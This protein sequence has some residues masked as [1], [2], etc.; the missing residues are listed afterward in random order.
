MAD[1]IGT[2]D[3]IES[4]DFVLFNPRVLVI[5]AAT[6]APDEAEFG[7]KISSQDFGVLE[8]RSEPDT[9]AFIGEAQYLYDADLV[10]RYT[11]DPKPGSLVLYPAATGLEKAMADTDAERLIRIPDWV[12]IDQWDPWLISFNNL[13]FLA[14]AMSANMWQDEWREMTKRAWVARQ[15]EFKSLRG[16]ENGLRMAVDFIGR[17]VSPWGYQVTKL[18][19]PPQRVYSGPTMTKEE[20][21]AWLKDMP[22]IRL[23]RVYE[24]GWAGFGKS[25]YGGSGRARILHNHRF[26]LGGPADDPKVRAITP[27][28]ALER[29][30]HRARYIVRGVETDVTVT[31]FGEFHRL[32]LRGIE[33]GSVFTRRVIHT[34]GKK[35]YYIPTTAPS[36]LIT[37]MPKE[38]L[39]WRTPVWA[40]REPLTAEGD[41]VV[42]NSTRRRSVFSDIPSTGPRVPNERSWYYVPSDAWSRIYR[43]YPI[44]DGSTELNSRRPVQ[45][46]GVGRYGFPKY[47]AWVGMSLRS[48]RPFAVF[49][50]IPFNRYY[51]P[52]DPT[53]VKRAKVAVRAAKKIADRVLLEL[54]P[55]PSFVAGRPF[56]AGKNVFIVGRTI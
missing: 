32:H 5:L 29:T 7:G 2:L 35:R 31:D 1:I 55:V 14:W 51:Q 23:W 17:D 43:R 24:R 15:W 54:G 20:R 53:P 45:F 16:T 38:R 25:F 9:A 10:N 11:P 46:M 12:I 30:K 28:T 19:V 49:N 18:T 39:S 37:I 22:Q 6:D 3:A 8:T 47:T 42:E 36:R 13:P 50:G 26:C 34:T 33:N 40:S 48:K 21:E 41:R 27:S 4:T 44:N 52:H 56:F